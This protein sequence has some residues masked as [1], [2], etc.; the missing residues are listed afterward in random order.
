M[1]VILGERRSMSNPL[2]YVMLIGSNKF[3]AKFL[4]LEKELTFKNGCCVLLPYWHGMMNKDSYSND[5]W[6]WLMAYGYAKI[7]I[8]D[9][10]V[11]LN[12]GGYI[13]EHTQREIDHARKR[14]K[15]VRYLESVD[16]T[17]E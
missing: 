6:E 15:E 5:D 9:Y 7:D 12:V 17:N 10:V 2:K 4:E 8:A 14:G 3:N 1:Q 11:V 13:G 16:I